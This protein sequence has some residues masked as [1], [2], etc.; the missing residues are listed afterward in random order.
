MPREVSFRCGGLLLVSGLAALIAVLGLPRG[1]PASYPASAQRL[2]VKRE[3][4]FGFGLELIDEHGNVRGRL[5]AVPGLNGRVVTSRQGTAF[6]YVAVS[7]DLDLPPGVPERIRRRLARQPQASLAFGTFLHDVIASAGG[8]GTF[9]LS[10]GTKVV[11]AVPGRPAWSRDGRRI[12]VS[13]AQKGRVHLFSYETRGL[14]RL[15]QLTQSPGRDLNPRFSPDGGA[16]VFERHVAGQASLFSIRADGT[17]LRQLT[18]WPLDELSPDFAPDGRSIVFSSNASGRFQLY[19][20]STA[21]GSVRRLTSDYGNDSRPVWSPDGRWIAFS[22]DRDGD[23]DVYLIDPNGSLDRKL[24]HN[25]SED[26]VEDWQPLR[27]AR[28]PLVRALPSSGSRGKAAQLRYS[29]R[30]ESPVARVVGA[31]KLPRELIAGDT[32]PSNR[33]PG[34]VRTR[35]RRV[36]VLRVPYADLAPRTEE[37]EPSAEPPRRFHF[38]VVAVDPFGNQSGVSCASFHFR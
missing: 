17:R 10:L 21:D 14:S 8:G 23:S 27:D 5:A 13:Q 36:H 1:A 25:A 28:A 38:C 20:L 24:T 18:Y 26:L 15:R 11:P 34:I 22:S 37:G 35:P 7:S 29:L 33:G 2:L 32:F 9:T 3:A 19:A 31:V 6:S 12:V 30:E 4:V 16:I